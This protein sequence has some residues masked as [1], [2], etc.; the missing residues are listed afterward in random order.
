MTIIDW[1]PD[2]EDASPDASKLECV[3]RADPGRL[4]A[5]VADALVRVDV[6]E[7]DAAL[8]ADVLVDA[9]L[10][11]SETHGVALLNTHYVLGIQRGEINPRPSISVRRGRSTTITVDG[12]GGLGMVV[13]ARAMTA[14][15][16]LADA[17]GSGWATCFNTTHSAAGGYYVRMAA[18]RRMIGFH[19]SSGG[20]TIAPPGGSGRLLGNNPFSFGA[21]APTG[22]PFVL[23][24]APSTTIRPKIRMLGWAGRQLPEN[25]AVDGD[26]ASITDPEEFF[27]KQG[28]I[29]PL[30]GTPAGGGYKGFGMLLVSDIM[31]GVLSG[32][33]GSLVRAK[34]VHTSAFG[35]LA[36]D[37]F[38]TGAE[39]DTAFGAMVASLHGAE[40]PG[41]DP[42]RYP[43][44]R[45][46]ASSDERVRDGIPIRR[47][48]RDDLAQ[49]ADTLGMSMDEIWADDT[50]PEQE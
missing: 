38:P 34:G 28:A 48:V 43:G 46:Q 4:R 26:G 13:G 12:D 47:F 10:R 39:Y 42:V 25:W 24:M 44:E 23:D 50:C 32:D 30:G 49:M 27:A 14:C 33:G 15:L 22:G 31:T 19:W 5:F 11:A 8:C 29:L 9:D 20:S 41:G 3:G 6:P 21:P 37:G 7:A 18:A 1:T 35:A 17:H 40:G 36:V 16:D 2:A 45:A